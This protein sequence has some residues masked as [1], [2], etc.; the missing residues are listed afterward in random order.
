MYTYLYLMIAVYNVLMCSYSYNVPIVLR[1]ITGSCSNTCRVLMY[2][3]LAGKEI[4]LHDG[5]RFLCLRRGVR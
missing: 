2:T 5:A 1:L 4:R 3:Y